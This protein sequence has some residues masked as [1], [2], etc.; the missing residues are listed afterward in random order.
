MVANPVKFQLMY[1]GHITNFDNLSILIGKE[2]LLPTDEV[3]LLGV[4]I[5][6]KLS[7]N[8][9]IKGFCSEG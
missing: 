2:K 9:H 3:K 8:A 5:D 7:F 4:K 6:R 1:L